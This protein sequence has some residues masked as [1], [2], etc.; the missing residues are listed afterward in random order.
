[1][2]SID[3]VKLENVTPDNIQTYVKAGAK[4]DRA[5]VLINDPLLRGAWENVKRD[6]TKLTMKSEPGSKDSSR[7]HNMYLALEAVE[8]E[9]E[10]YIGGGKDASSIL[11]ALSQLE[12][13]K[14]AK[15]EP[16]RQWVE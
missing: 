1:M 6:L 14:E 9:I 15:A 7:W 16:P 5:N 8:R 13:D 10:S 3:P 2:R 11:E 12:A 4:G